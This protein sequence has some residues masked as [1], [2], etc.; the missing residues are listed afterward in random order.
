MVYTILIIVLLIILLAVSGIT[1]FGFRQITQMKL[2][3]SDGLFGFMEQMGVYSR[4][5]FHALVKREARVT[6]R[7]GLL[8]HGYVLE[9]HPDSKRWMIIVHG[10]TAS[11]EVAAQFIGMFEDKGF[12]IL[13]IDQRRH[14]RSEGSYTTYGYQEKYD[15]E[16]WVKWVTDHYGE[17]IT[18][19]LHGQSLGGGTVLEYLSIAHPNVKF[20]IADCPYSDLTELIRH[21]MTVL[22]KVPAFPFMPL[23]DQQLERKAGF[24][25][26]QVS[27]IKAVRSSSLPVLFIH[28]S[29][30]TYVPTHMSEDM[31]AVKPGP[32]DLL[33]VRGAVHANAYGVDPKGYTEK[34]QH[35]IDEVLRAAP[36]PEAYPTERETSALTHS[37]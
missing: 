19:G 7:D 1:R 3:T 9:P 22:N 36:A 26:A 6:S 14:G 33:I 23:I 34:V 15:I 29:E 28:G 20:V 30:D 12:N 2:Q 31:Y 16:T 21:Q 10:Y 17:D 11:L 4:E 27:P 5:K 32:K 25:L 18:I 13:L 35:F 24:R 37:R 8:L